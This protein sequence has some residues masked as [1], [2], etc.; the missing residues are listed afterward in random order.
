MK[1]LNQII[2][3]KLLESG[4]PYLNRLS[5]LFFIISRHLDEIDNEKVEYWKK[6]EKK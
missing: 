4:V 6:P 1:S 3:N 2:K 5:D